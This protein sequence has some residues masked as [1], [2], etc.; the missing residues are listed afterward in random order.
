MPQLESDTHLL[1]HGEAQSAEFF[2]YAQAEQA[3]RLHLVDQFVRN[4]VGFGD[5]I[6]IG[7]EA[8]AHEARNVVEQCLQYF[9]VADHGISR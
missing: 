1:F 4:G 3:Q 8:L 7:N 5:Q 6:F 9:G 2:G